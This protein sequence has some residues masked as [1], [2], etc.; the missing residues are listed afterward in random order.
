M[1]HVRRVTIVDWTHLLEDY[2][3][4]IGVSR[5][6]YLTEMTGGWLFGF[7]EALAGAG[8]EA[9]VYGVSG[10]VSSTEVR[11]HRPT[12]A[13]IRLFPAPRLYRAIRRVVWNPYGKSVE[14]AATVGRGRRWLATSLWA[15]APY[16]AT[17][18]IQLARALR[19]DRVDAVLCQEYEHPR[20]DLLVGL[21]RLLGVPV[22]GVYQGGD[23]ATTPAER[24]TRARAL[25]RG[26]G[27]IVGPSAEVERVRE[28]Y[29]VPEERIA[30]VP[31]PVDTELW[32][33]GSREAARRELGVPP[34][35]RV[36]MWH[37]RVLWT[38]KGLDVLLDAWKRL[39]AE[40][41]DERWLLLIGDGPDAERLR[42]ALASGIPN[43][44][45]QEGYVNDRE[46]LARW[47]SAGDVG[48]LPS[49]DEGFPVAPMEVMAAGL[50][51]VA[52]EVDAVRD[53]FPRGEVD[54]GIIVPREDPV[55]LAEAL[56]S[57]LDDPERSSTLGAAAV[58]R[59]GEAFSPGAVGR[60]LVDAL[61]DAAVRTGAPR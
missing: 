12:G 30:R 47:V 5:E 35:A 6:A 23:A 7:V 51:V 19:E 41:G 44:R 9:V 11:R 3:D 58:R 13:R 20:F 39:G 14:E 15:A 8:V 49:R 4:A 2:L 34:G 10:R 53:L 21:G 38:R 1:R 48:V 45:W 18:M 42:A 61:E 33:S 60:A 31:N 29:G 24:L 37:G 40:G 22:L 59:V 57:L 32:A 16:S 55:R 46:V 25:R 43:V 52:S 27:L 26:D 50:P 17:P 54:G 28:R 36:A 56:S